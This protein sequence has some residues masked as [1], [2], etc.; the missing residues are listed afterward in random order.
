[1]V[2]VAPIGIVGNASIGFNYK[3][4]AN[5]LPA[6]RQEGFSQTTPFVATQNNFRSRANSLSDPFPTGILQ[7]VGSSQGASTFLGQQI[8]FFSPE[9]RNPYCLRWNFGIQR[10]L[11]GQIILEVAY[12]GKHRIHLLVATT[13]MD[14]V[15]ARYLSTSPV[16]DQA[17]INSLTASVPNPF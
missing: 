8:Q 4:G 3:N 1:G 6:L 12:I 16:R 10:Q 2:F 17:V 14:F 7:P 15:P 13:N 5:G 9:V 11:P